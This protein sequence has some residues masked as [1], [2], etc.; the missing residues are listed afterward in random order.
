MILK[1]LKMLIGVEKVMNPHSEKKTVV[2]GID[3]KQ[4]DSREL[5]KNASEVRIRHH[6]LE[7]RLILTKND[8]LILIK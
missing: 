6:A 3:C 1:K 2:P 4:L 5:F 7:Y 8:K